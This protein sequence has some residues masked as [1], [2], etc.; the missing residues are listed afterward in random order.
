MAQRPRAT[1]GRVIDDLGSTLI[2]VIAGDVDAGTEVG[3][4]AIHDPID[5]PVMPEG[6]LLLGVGLAGAEEIAG[7]LREAGAAGAAGLIVRVPIE[8]SRQVREAVEETGVALFGLTRGASWAQVAAMLRSLLAVDDLG[9]DD[10]ETLAGAAAGDLFAMANAVSALLD[11]PVTIEDLNSRVLAFSA[12]QDVADAPRKETVL[13]RQVPERFTRE[14]ERRGVFREMYGSD[15]PVYVANLPGVDLPRV[16]VRVSAGDEILGSIWAAVSKPLP[17]EREQALLDSA[18]LVALHMLRQRAGADVERRLQAEL[19]ATLVEGGP[20]APEAAERLGVATGPSCVMA[21]ALREGSD[22]SAVEAELQRVSGA[23]ALH[24]GA[25]HHRSAVALV[26][27]V[28]YGVVPLARRDPEADRRAVAIA[29]EFLDRIGDH[30]GV[31]IGIGRSAADATELPRS[32]A[33]ADRALRVLRNGPGPSRV[34]R[35]EDVWAAS[36]LLELGDLMAA[37]RQE[38]AGAVARLAA[39]DARHRGEMVETLR[40]W[41]DAFGDVAAAAA[42]LHVHPN[43]FRYRLRRIRQI[44]EIDLDDPEARFAAMLELR[45]NSNTRLR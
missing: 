16:A 36:L 28:V 23:F 27:G 9:V 31:V 24:L 13:G 44:A 22:A 40:A 35:A 12:N 14:L 19:V 43:T 6:T 26:G 7:V 33:D 38:L 11:A 39:Y 5:P 15:R 2:E 41:L 17:A 29:R 10:G 3:G 37:D 42:Q 34:A 21:L 45:L 30:S 8:M 1:L 20:T 4:V 32:R 18:T 25:T